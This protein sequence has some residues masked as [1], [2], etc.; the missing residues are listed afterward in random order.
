MDIIE[1]INGTDVFS[2]VDIMNLMATSEVGA[3][4]SVVLRDMHSNKR[5]HVNVILGSDENNN[6]V[7]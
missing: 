6:N 3:N 1:S 4:M 7:K 2:T 5:R